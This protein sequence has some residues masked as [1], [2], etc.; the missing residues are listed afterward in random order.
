MPSVYVDT[1]Q[2][3]DNLRSISEPGRSL[4]VSDNAV[5][6]K[7][8]AITNNNGANTL[9]INYAN[10]CDVS[11]DKIVGRVYQNRAALDTSIN[12]DRD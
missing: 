7:F 11:G 5:K 8:S 12:E 3:S 4:S 6:R 10:S 1:R 9:R 2:I